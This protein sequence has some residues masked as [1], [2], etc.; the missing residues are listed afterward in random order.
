MPKAAAWADVRLLGAGFV[1]MQRGRGRPNADM[2]STFFETRQVTDPAAWV[3]F[4]RSPRRSHCSVLTSAVDQCADGAREA[5][6]YSIV[7]CCG[8]ACSACFVLTGASAFQ[9]PHVTQQAVRT[10]QWDRDVLQPHRHRQTTIIQ[11][12]PWCLCKALSIRRPG[13]TTCCEHQRLASSG[14]RIRTRT[15]EATVTASWVRCLRVSPDRVC[16]DSGSIQKDM[17][18]AQR[19][20]PRRT[21]C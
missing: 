14:S 9:R 1:G 2:L 12:I 17:L 11:D 8:R 13:S 10:Q 16:S 7:V 3:D 5:R 21:A 6:Q 19:N 18:C 4:L 15:L 20:F